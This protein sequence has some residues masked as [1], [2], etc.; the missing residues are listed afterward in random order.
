MVLWILMEIFCSFVSCTD[1][2]TAHLLLVFGDGDYARRVSIARL[3]GRGVVRGRYIT[4]LLVD[5]LVLRRRVV[6]ELGHHPPQLLAAAAA[7]AAAATAAAVAVTVPLR[8]RRHRRRGRR[9][10]DIGFCRSRRKRAFK[11]GYFFD[12]KRLK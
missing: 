6:A 4:V 3:C 5:D 1:D 9:D 12:M 2:R 8:R 10:D 7:A 11:R